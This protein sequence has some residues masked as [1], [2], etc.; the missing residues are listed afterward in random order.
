MR[1][2]HRIQLRFNTDKEKK[3]A[4]LP[5]WRVLI[6]GVEYLAD[7]VFV[8][9]PLQTSEDILPS[10]EKKWHVSCEGAVEWRD[11]VCHIVAP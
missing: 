10:G 1:N 11:R 9:V 3:D 8:N 2:K 4:S 7:Q 5:P 6:D